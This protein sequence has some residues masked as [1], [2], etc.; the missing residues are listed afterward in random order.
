MKLLLH[1][2]CGPCS[3]S[4]IERLKREGFALSGFFYNPNIHPE[5]EYNLRL[6]AAKAVAEKEGVSLIAAIYD[7][8]S[9]KEAIRGHESEEEGG[10]RCAICIEKRLK[11]TAQYCVESGFSIFATTLSV[12]PHKSAQV[13]NTIGT[14]VAKRFKIAF[15]SADFKK[16]NGF[17]ISCRKAK[18]LGLYRQRYCGCRYSQPS[19]SAKI[20]SNE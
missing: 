5:A 17:A 7:P 3:L 2:C 12:S 14:D 19:A 9:W 11:K 4:V 8:E 6:S 15:Y 20:Y 1:I 13:I 18:E 10:R 16:D